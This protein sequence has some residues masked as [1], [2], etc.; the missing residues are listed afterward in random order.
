MISRVNQSQ[1]NL[2]FEDI[3]ADSVSC[4][5]S[6]VDQENQNLSAAEKELLEEH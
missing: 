4:S 5:L 2:S 6:L 1:V 3:S